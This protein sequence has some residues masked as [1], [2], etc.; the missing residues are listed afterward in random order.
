M[1]HPT[2]IIGSEAKIAGNVEIGPHSV[3][4]SI[5]QIID[6]LQAHRERY[7]CSYFVIHD[8]FMELLA[9]IVA[10]LTAT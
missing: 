8:D 1:I 5:D 3:I 2:A 7:K 10:R 9:P 6:S 4:G